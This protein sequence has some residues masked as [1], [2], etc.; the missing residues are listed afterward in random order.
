MEIVCSLCFNKLHETHDEHPA[1]VGRLG[2]PTG[3]RRRGVFKVLSIHERRRPRIVE[4]RSC[5]AGQTV[6]QTRRTHLARRPQSQEG[7]QQHIGRHWS[8]QNSGRPL[9]RFLERIRQTTFQTLPNQ[10]RSHRASESPGKTP[11]E[12]TPV[13]PQPMEPS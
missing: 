13:I 6:P 7:D 1:G 8:Q 12:V 5:V 11:F 9:G 4:A 2:R 10:T 3:S